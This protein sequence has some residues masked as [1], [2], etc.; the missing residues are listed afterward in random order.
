M[1]AD[2]AAS[3]AMRV[4]DSFENDTRDRCVDIFVRQ[5]GSYGFEEWRREPEDPG[6]WFRTRYHAHAQFATAA[7]AIAAARIAIA[8]F[9]GARPG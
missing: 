1:A 7:A 2:R 4:I 9:E 8:W 5:D 6:R 3:A